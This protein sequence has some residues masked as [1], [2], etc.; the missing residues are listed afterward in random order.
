MSLRGST[1][2]FNSLN[3]VLIN[4]CLTKVKINTLCFLFRMILISLVV[5][6]VVSPHCAVYPAALHRRKYQDCNNEQKLQSHRDS[7]HMYSVTE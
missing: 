2:S 1:L 3:L 6:P 7:N 4:V 5:P